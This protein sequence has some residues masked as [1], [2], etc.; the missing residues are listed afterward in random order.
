MD[1][2]TFN[3]LYE[4]LCQR[5]SQEKLAKKYEYD[6]RFDEQRKISACVIENGFGTGAKGF[7]AVHDRTHLK[8]LSRE[9]FRSYIQDYQG[10]KEKNLD[11]FI[12]H[13]NRKHSAN[14]KTVA[15]SD[16]AKQYG[17]QQF[18]DFN[19]DS[20]DYS[21]NNSTPKR[22]NNSIG[23]LFISIVVFAVLVILLKIGFP[24]VIS[25]LPN[26]SSIFKKD[27]SVASFSTN[28]GNYIGEVNSKNKSTGYG[29]QYI[30][31]DHFYLGKFKNNKKS[32]EGIE[33]EGANYF[34]MGI[35]N[36]DELD[37]FGIIN[38]A[39]TL[40]IGDMKR[41]E[42]N[43]YIVEISP[44]YD[45]IS[46]RN[47]KK[48]KDKD[49][50]L[51]FDKATGNVS[52]WDSKRPYEKSDLNKSFLLETNKK[53]SVKS[54]EIGD[55]YIFVGTIKKGEN[56][57]LGIRISNNNTMSYGY[58]KGNNLKNSINLQEENILFGDY[59]NTLKNGKGMDY[60]LTEPIDSTP[61]LNGDI[62]IGYFNKALRHGKGMYIFNDG[63]IISTTYKN[64]VRD[65]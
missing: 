44:T 30:N 58:W 15:R 34:A 48:G 13:I 11:D 19:N 24:R 5:I 2:I 42:M 32:G 37:G 31:K 18:I 61:V 60:L 50:I 9:E 1:E 64:N 4:N 56:K 57:G 45:N 51:S 40:Y 33:K 49:I 17:Q 54:I 38:K 53:T 65:N 7:Q 43:G 55:N 23:G 46:I 3:I 35:Y 26:L 8:G 62:Y 25:G 36:K 21:Q 59:T 22:T 39:G 52:Y 28:N 41:G 12:A 20:N 6:P 14:Q 10:S 47:Y 27:I 16:N 29:I 63:Y